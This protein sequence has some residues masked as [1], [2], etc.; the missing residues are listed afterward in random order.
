MPFRLGL[1]NGR[2]ILCCRVVLVICRLNCVASQ[3][4]LLLHMQCFVY[5]W[6]K[7]SS[8]PL[9]LVSFSSFLFVCAARMILCSRF[10][11]I[12]QSTTGI[13]E[14]FLK[15]ELCALGHSVS[16][17]CVAKSR[18]AMYNISFS[19][20]R[21]IESFSVLQLQTIKSLIPVQSI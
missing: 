5:L 10:L 11:E 15:S 12:F 1:T 8:P 19:Y 4:L 17:N 3:L 14:M 20:G 7:S 16:S 18:W 2:N 6:I 13:L 9:E 21:D